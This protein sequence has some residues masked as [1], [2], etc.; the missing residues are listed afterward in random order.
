MRAKEAPEA[1]YHT[2]LNRVH[3]SSPLGGMCELLPCAGLRPGTHPGSDVLRRFHA[4]GSGVFAPPPAHPPSQAN[5]HHSPAAAEL[6]QKRLS[7]PLRPP[8]AAAATEAD[9]SQGSESRY[10]V[11]QGTEGQMM[12]VPSRPA[13]RALVP[14]AENM[15]DVTPR[16][17]P[18]SV[19][20]SLAPVAFGAGSDSSSLCA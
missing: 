16:R 10:S 7:T 17:C 14:S 9:A 12:A 5:N 13:V 6:P 15:T 20:S 11:C 8:K 2:S 19:R 4:T 18:S 1:K 3:I